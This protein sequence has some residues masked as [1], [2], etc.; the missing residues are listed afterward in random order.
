MN[1]CR[2][3]AARQESLSQRVARA[4]QLLSTR[5][6]L[7]REQQNQ[8]VL[9]SM[10]RRAAAQL[11]LQ[12]TVEGLSIAAMTYYVVGLVG[13]AAKGAKAAGVA[14]DPELAMASAFR[15][16]CCSGSR[17]AQGAQAISAG[18]TQRDEL[19]E[20]PRRR[21]RGVPRAPGAR[22]LATVPDFALRQDRS[23]RR[24]RRRNGAVLQPTISCSGTARRGR[25]RCSVSRSQPAIISSVPPHARDCE[26]AG[27]SASPRGRASSRC[28]RPGAHGR[29]VR[30]TPR[31]QSRAASELAASSSPP[32]EKSS[33]GVR[34]R[35]QRAVE[36]DESL[37]AR[38]CHRA[39]CAP[40]SPHPRNGQ[41]PVAARAPGAR[42]VRRS[43]RAMAGNDDRPAGRRAV[44]PCPGRSMATT[45]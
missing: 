27:I 39:P 10:N 41:R 42:A 22:V 31:E 12:Q 35:Q 11:R 21:T 26:S 7:T 34:Q 30:R 24:F 5:V 37:V 15:W 40:R 45:R 18:H 8:A 44:K 14:V 2:A 6:D 32:A 13:Y 16:C 25:S 29:R 3:A 19:V 23:T 17:P 33:L 4:T 43:S 1:T 38:A 28:C 9:D 36:A 20:G